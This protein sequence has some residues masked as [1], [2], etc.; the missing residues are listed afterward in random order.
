MGKKSLVLPLIISVLWGNQAASKTISNGYRYLNENAYQKIRLKNGSW[1]KNKNGGTSF[2]KIYFS[3]HP[4]IPFEGP[5]YDNTLS[6][7]ELWPM[8]RRYTENIY[9]LILTSAIRWMENKKEIFYS[10]KSGLPKDTYWAFLLGALS[11]PHHE[12]NLMHFRRANV[13]DCSDLRNSTMWLDYFL[14]D[15]FYEKKESKVAF[16]KENYYNS[17]TPVFPACEFL[18]HE[19]HITQLIVSNNDTGL[20]QIN[21]N[22]HDEMR[23]PDALFNLYKHIDYALKEWMEVFPELYQKRFSDYMIQS[24]DGEILCTLLKNPYT[25]K[26]GKRPSLVVPLAQG[27][28]AGK[29]N[30]GNILP[31]SVCR[32]QMRNDDRDKAYELRTLYSILDLKEYKDE[33]GNNY[34]SIYDV[35]M[36]KESIE[37][38]SLL[39]LRENIAAFHAVPGAKKNRFDNIKKVVEKY[40]TILNKEIL[41]INITQLS[42]VVSEGEYYLSIPELK[43]FLSPDNYTA[44]SY[45]GNIVP[46]EDKYF[47]LNI[48]SESLEV[49]K[50]IGPNNNLIE[51]WNLVQI[52]RLRNFSVNWVKN[53]PK[54][55][56]KEKELWALTAIGAEKLLQKTGYSKLL[57]DNTY[58]VELNDKISSS[59]S[60]RADHYTTANHLSSLMKT[61]D[62]K[63]KVVQEWRSKHNTKYPYWLQIEYKKDTYGWIAADFVRPVA[64]QK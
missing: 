33:K 56:K 44:K 61:D 12:S 17:K 42:P 10:S 46:E 24:D 6:D 31:E 43:L 48:V 35:Y 63:V 14:S 52:P 28:W 16:F 3:L 25:V 59:L 4:E 54:A 8:G 26:N 7:D 15:S 29:H 49:S 21:I 11:I 13:K 40:S 60:I 45:C 34:A 50:N 51:Q 47:T 20:M 37:Y 2:G 62:P 39:E 19:P 58:M 5:F 36:N 55:C 23:H 9:G 41:P 32:P 57:P 18:Q 38:K 30:Q 64:E 1:K 22:V 53:A 27:L